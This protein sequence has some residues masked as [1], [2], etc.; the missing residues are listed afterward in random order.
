MFRSKYWGPPSICTTHA[1]PL[2]DSGSSVTWTVLL[3]VTPFAASLAASIFVL[4]PGIGVAGGGGFQPRPVGEYRSAY[5]MSVPFTK[6]NFL[7]ES[8]RSLGTDAETPEGE[9][10]SITTFVL[11]R[12]TVPSAPIC[13]MFIFQKTAS[14]RHF[15]AS[16]PAAPI[17]LSGSAFLLSIPYVLV[18]ALP[19]LN[20]FLRMLPPML[21]PPTTMARPI[22]PT[23]FRTG[24]PGG[25]IATPVM[26]AG[27]CAA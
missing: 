13:E 11:F 2:P 4:Q 19:G 21:S 27:A 23:I 20:L 22:A 14:L 12:S 18:L 15:F 5:R 24:K 7:M 9:K 1:G 25:F 6:L 10:Y 3:P 17:I 16:V 8:S 26:P